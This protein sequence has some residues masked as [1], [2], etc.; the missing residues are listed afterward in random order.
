MVMA[1]WC[2]LLLSYSIIC[3]FNTKAITFSFDYYTHTHTYLLREPTEV[4]L[5]S[6]HDTIYVVI[7]YT[8]GGCDDDDDDSFLIDNFI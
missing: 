8:P 7:V 3:I 1:G 6:S 5:V 2:L 4:V